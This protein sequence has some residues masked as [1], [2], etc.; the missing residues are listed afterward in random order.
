MFT[1]P[2]DFL[3]G[4]VQHSPL[5]IDIDDQKAA[6][7]RL[8]L[9]VAALQAAA[10]SIVIT[11]NQGT[12]LWFNQAF[13]QLT[14]YRSEEVLGKNPRFLKS[15]EHGSAFYK[16]MWLTIA[17]GNTWHGEITNRRKNGSLYAEEMTITPVRFS[18]DEITHYVAI[19]QDV[20]SRK[21]AEDKLRRAEATYRSIFEDAVIGIFQTTPDGRP[22]SFNR[23]MARLHGYD[24]PEELLAEVS[25]VG[26]QLFVDPNALQELASALEVQRTLRSI[27]LEVFRKDGSK[28]WVLA[29][30]RA[31]T[32]ADGKVVHHEVTAED[33][34]DRKMAEEFLREKAAMQELLSGI[35]ATVPGVVYTFLMQPDGSYAFPFASS[36]L[37]DIFAISPD[38]VKLDATA[39][40]AMVH[41][42]DLSH[43]QEAIAVSSR[44]LTPW[45]EEFRVN[46]PKNGEI[47]VEGNSY[48]KRQQD[49]SVLWHGFLSEI[50][51]RK[52]LES[53]LHQTQMLESIGNLAGGV[54]HDF[55]NLMSIVAGYCD[56]IAED[57][58][59]LHPNLPQLTKIVDAAN[60]ATELT[61]QLLAFGRRQVRTAVAINLNEN[62]TLFAK[63]LARLLK[64]D[65]NLTLS[66]DPNLWTAK[67]DSTQI[68]QVLMNLAVNARDAMPQGG[69]L[70]IGTLN[71]DLEECH[72]TTDPVMRP[73][74]FVMISVSDTG[75]GMSPEVMSHMFEPF[76]STKTKN[77]GSGTGMGLSTVF[78]IVKQNGG[79]IRA[80]SNEGAGTTFNVYLPRD[81]SPTQVST[82]KQG[83]VPE[84]VVSKTIL[85]TDDD[86]HV[87]QIARLLLQR[88]GY[89]VLEARDG[90]EAIR[91]AEK[92]EGSI[93]LLLTDVVMPGM[94]GRELADHLRQDNPT[95]KV[96]FV[97]GYADEIVFREG[98]L[99]SGSYFLP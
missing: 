16:D 61:G 64:E 74:E 6:N 70:V 87:R 97:S 12:I 56:L 35:I 54:A 33:I 3:A 36:R 50:T 93:D 24:S 78:G 47:W 69:D 72:T 95:L 31:V 76:F 51:E 14:G 22:L 90:P 38:A 53:Q 67:A 18:N 29:N 30:A 44:C 46:H 92:H 2:T 34:T 86:P 60:R 1:N 77:I 79:F 8:L 20:T 84:I 89:A 11:D 73:G 37:H 52:R 21:I 88:L 40:L 94:N 7:E 75:V 96:L 15:G 42:E 65:I 13:S 82:P 45:H 26:R 85:L 49:D 66:L 58:G 83:T 57:L 4:L 68:D 80:C 27:E 43:L 48:P 98:G 63:M 99:D 19:K 9:Q 71:V 39:A 28:R 81:G 55:N 17:S 41:P 10:N 25:N 23:A 91:L 59:P 62:I 32:D 5:S